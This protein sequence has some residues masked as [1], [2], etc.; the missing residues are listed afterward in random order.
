[1]ATVGAN[2]GLAGHSRAVSTH[3]SVAA[4]DLK[5]KDRYQ[6]VIADAVRQVGADIVLPISDAASRA[7]LGTE[8]LIGARVAGPSLEAYERASDKAN[9]LIIAQSLD[10]RVPLQVA[11][12]A[13]GAAFH[14]PD[15]HAGAV[16]LKP[17]RSIVDVAGQSRSLGVKFVADVSRINDA[18][19][20]YPAEAYPILVQ[21]RT[22]GDGIGVFLLRTHG[23]THLQFAHK[24]LREKP[25]AGGVSTYREAVAPPPDLVARCEALL[26]ALHYHGP[27]MIEFKRDDVTGEYVLME[28]NAR[29]W[30]SLQLA[31]DAGVDFPFVLAELTMGRTVPALPQVNYGVRSVWELG[32]VD[33]AFALWR[34]S[35]TRLH[36]P[37]TLATGGRA[38]IRALFDHRWSDRAEVFRWSDPLPFASE[39][40]RWLRNT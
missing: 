32:E 10:I 34:H 20:S 17:A 2:R 36:A 31:I 23:Q 29:M 19:K 39:V 4:D 30:G 1:M 12:P 27:A 16:V 37:E 26:D 24:R 33:H 22:F 3:V 18:L 40:F 7:L 11:I 15:T 6:H 25:P 9:L 21:E 13:E 28:I 14:W 8:Q 38:A 5:S 35:R